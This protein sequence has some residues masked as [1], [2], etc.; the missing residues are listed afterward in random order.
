MDH[1]DFDFDSDFIDPIIEFFRQIHLKAEEVNDSIFEALNFEDD[2]FFPSGNIVEFEKKLIK[3]SI[4]WEIM[5]E[6]QTKKK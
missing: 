6:R 2:Y 5:E 1:N 4:I 3:S